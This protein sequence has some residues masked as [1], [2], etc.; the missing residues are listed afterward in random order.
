MCQA[1]R[2]HSGRYGTCR[3]RAELQA[4]DYQVHSAHAGCA[5]SA[6]SAVTLVRTAHHKLRCSCARGPNR[7]LGQPA[8]T[9]PNRVWVGDITYLPRQGG[10]WLYL[11]TWLDRCSRKVVGWDVRETMPEGLVSE[12]LRRALA[13]WRPTAGLIVHSAQGSQYAATN[14]KAL[15]AQHGAQQSMS[16][17]GNCYDNAHAES[18]WSRLKTE[19]LDGGSFPGLAEARLEISHYIAYYNAERRHS[20]LGY[21]TPNYFETQLQTT[22]PF[23]PA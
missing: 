6:C 15:L 9:A 21:R 4:Q 11:A 13:V 5:R 23:C 14:F 17:R 18:F 7:L 12:A 22:S 10:G 2:R 16:Q 20:A 3:L 1:F 8:P 19:L